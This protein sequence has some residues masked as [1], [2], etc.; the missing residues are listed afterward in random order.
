MDLNAAADLLYALP[1]AEFTAARTALVKEVKATDA[2][3]SREIAGLRRPTVVAWAVNQLVRRD[4]P[5]LTELLTLGEDLRQAWQDQDARAL[6]ALSARRTGLTAVVTRL[7]ADL[8]AASGQRLATLTE[9][10]QTLDA[11]VV[12]AEAAARVR[13]ATLTTALAYSGFAPAPVPATPRTPRQ[14]PA[15]REARRSRELAEAAAQ[16]EQEA[17]ESEAALADWARE[18]ADAVRER[19]RRA[20]KLAALETKL[21][22]IESKLAAAREKHTQAAKRADLAQRDETRARR[23]AEAARARATAARSRAPLP[24]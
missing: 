24:E 13:Q 5:E 21:A 10:E 23:A 1:P 3:L 19:E 20:E 8:A 6:A 4:P 9:V 7:V 2:A 22:E 15:D 11:A 12:D 14:P 18:L 16:A 17:A